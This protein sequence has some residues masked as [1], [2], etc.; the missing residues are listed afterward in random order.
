[1]SGP[2]SALYGPNSAS[3]IMHIIT[4]SPLSSKTN[5]VSVGGGERE[6]FIG[7]FTHSNHF[8][9]RVGYKISGQYYRGIDW[10]S[11]DDYEPDSIRL[12][13]PTPYGPVYE[14]EVIENNRDFDIEK[15]SGEARVDYL[16]NPDLSIVANGGINSSSDIELTGVGAAQAVDWT[17]YFGQVRMNWKNLFAQVYLNASDAGDTYILRTG[18]RV[19][20]KSR[21]WSGQI[22]HNIKAGDKIDFVYGFD[23]FFT[24]PNTEYTINGRNED[25]DNSNEY[26]I[27]LQAEVK[28]THKLKFIEATRLDL[29][30]RLDGLI[31]SPRSAVTYQPD[32]NNNFRLTYNRAYST[33]SNTNFYLDML[34]ADDPFEIGAALEP[35][36]GF[37]P[38][39]DVRIQGV[40]ESGFH[41]SVNSSGPQFR[42]SFAPLDPRG[43]GEDDFID[44]NDPV[45]VNVMWATG[46]DMVIAGFTDILADFG[47]PSSTIDS[48]TNSIRA[49]SPE[50]VSGVNNALMTF[51]LSTGSFEPTSIDQLTDI[52][53]LEPSY[54]NTFEFGYKGMMAE[55]LKVAVDLYYTRRNNFISFPIIE[56]PNV[57]LDQATLEDYLANEFGLT[58]SDS[59]NIEHLNVLIMLD[60]PQYGGN[61]NGTPVDE[62]TNIFSYGT[63]QIPFGTVTPI[64]AYDPED[65][66]VTFRNF[67]NVSLYGLDLS[68]NFDLD[69]NWSLGGNYS[70]ISRNIFKKSESRIHD[71]FLNSPRNKAAVYVQYK[72]ERTSF[73]SH[74]RGRYIDAFDMYSPFEGTRVNSYFIIDQHLMYSVAHNTRLILTVKNIFNNKHIEFIGAPKLGRLTI[75]RLVHSF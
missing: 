9:N 53:P 26:G 71:I 66:L 3:G 34:Q 21:F 51:D 57:F 17:Y 68:I 62:L 1:V 38:G 52:D 37:N 7:S 45:F 23:S 69:R 2:G 55:R 61:G 40:P 58:L 39:I 11:Y 10:N 6:I 70:Y 47:F 14:S 56:S 72:N 64:E 20:D 25:K 32:D 30:S 41:W 73:G 28:L 46:R 65:I 22:Q 24:R 19:I 12:Y 48:L 35:F 59:A 18:Q 5:T 54:T 42:S 4:K 13:R 67:G 31:F 75:L 63:A 36:I 49:V 60:Q 44:F 15:I 27:Y 16:I 74:T 29:H 50:T 43:L 8:N 33:P